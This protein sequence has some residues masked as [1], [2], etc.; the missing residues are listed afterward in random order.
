MAS[1]A[2]VIKFEIAHL[3]RQIDRIPAEHA[4]RQCHL[5]I[6][7]AQASQPPS[8]TW[9][10]LLR[11]CADLRGSARY[12]LPFAKALAHSLPIVTS[13]QSRATRAEVVC[14]LCMHGQ[15][16]LRVACRLESSH[17]AF[18]FPR[19]LVGVFGAVVE[20]AASPE[21]LLP[22]SPRAGGP[23]SSVVYR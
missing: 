10:Y 23:H 7:G 2:I 5:Q 3:P 11:L 16:T 22:A 21:A 14:D 8:S 13:T 18:A 20:P 12:R 1:A 4:I 9:S 17:S 15:E 19:R 6:E